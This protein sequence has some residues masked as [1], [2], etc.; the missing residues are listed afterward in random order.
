MLTLTNAE[1]DEIKNLEARYDP[2]AKFIVAKMA[3]R[4][5]DKA[6]NGFALAAGPHSHC[7][8]SSSMFLLETGFRLIG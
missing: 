1:H 6:K 8:S 3:F 7:R 4:G 5:A 2:P